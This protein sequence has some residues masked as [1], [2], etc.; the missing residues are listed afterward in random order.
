[1]K[2]N[3]RLVVLVASALAFIGVANA[4]G[5][6][7]NDMT[8]NQ[9]KL[10]AEHAEGW[11]EMDAARQEQIATGTARWLEMNRRQKAQAE[12]RFERCKLRYSIF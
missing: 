11:S 1:M 8:D 7:W 12:D 9:K 3:L 2:T 10:L 4:D 6:A 5:V